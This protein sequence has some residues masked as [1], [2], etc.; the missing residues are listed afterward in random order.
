MANGAEAIQLFLNRLLKRSVLN[1]AERA[2]ILA[3][4]MTRHHARPGED[5]VGLG[6]LVD[7]VAKSGGNA[8]AA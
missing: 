7:L 8:R 5:F 1:E 4:P 3:L 6:E 2:A